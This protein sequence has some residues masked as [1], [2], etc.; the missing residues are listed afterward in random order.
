[1][2]I[3]IESVP[4]ISEGR[5]IYLINL[6]AKT[7]ELSKVNLLD[8]HYD[9]DHNRSVFSFTG[10]IENVFNCIFNIT[11]IIYDKIDLN[12]HVGVHPRSGAIDI[13]PFIPIK[14]ISYKDLVKEVDEFGYKFFE[15][16]RIP[17][18]FYGFNSKVK[19]R[20]KMNKIRNLG[21]EKLKEILKTN[22]IDP[23]FKPDIYKDNFIHEKLG[24]SFIGVRKP[25]L[26]FNVNYKNNDKNLK[27]K[28]NNIAK[29]IRESSN[30]IKN[31]QAKVFY[32]QSKDL[33]QLSLNVLDILNTDFYFI[34]EKI[35]EYSIE[36]NLKIESTEIVGLMPTKTIENIL[37]NYL[38][39]S[40][41]NFKKVIEIE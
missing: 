23:F 13:I 29:K 16:F 8:I 25:L 9:W 41:F 6:I 14:N 28:L 3:I 7:I 15:K 36:L 32:L 21:F 22:E 40:N 12:K 11:E 19:D 2:D 30:G 18:Y 39:N 26:A 35:K 27:E 24:V 1:M 34:F 4:N 10:S 17:V 31:V 5:D 37:N 20:F 38:L 33:Y